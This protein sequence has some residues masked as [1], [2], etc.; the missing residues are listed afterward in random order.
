MADYVLFNPPQAAR[1]GQAVLAEEARLR[2]GHA[3]RQQRPAPLLP[4]G[5]VFTWADS[6]HAN[7]PAYGVFVQLA[8]S[9]GAENPEPRQRRVARR[10]RRPRATPRCR[11]S[12]SIARRTVLTRVRGSPT[13]E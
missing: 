7:L 13:W 3:G 9:Q 2:G 6:A 8:N 4:E 12:G 10:G 1:I 5:T 11:L